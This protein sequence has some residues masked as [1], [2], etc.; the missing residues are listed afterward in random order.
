VPVISVDFYPTILDMLGLKVPAE[1]KPDGVSIASLVK[2]EKKLD[3][4]AIYWHFPHYSNHGMQSPGGAIRSGDFKLLE[5][6]ENNTVQLYNL[7]ED[8]SEQNDISASNP[9]KVKELRTKLHQW[10]AKI[11]AQMMEPNPNYKSPK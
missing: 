6:F 8:L 4:D 1:Q 2:G 10:R 9:K 7:K 5:Y 3:R 11:N